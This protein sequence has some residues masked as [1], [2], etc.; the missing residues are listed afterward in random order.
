[1]AREWTENKRL[2]VTGILMGALVLGLGVVLGILVWIWSGVQAESADLGAQR[3]DAENTIKRYEGLNTQVADFKIKNRTDLDKMPDSDDG[4]ALS[5]DITK[6]AQG[7]GV[8]VTGYRPLKPA[9]VKPKQGRNPLQVV[10][11][12]QGSAESIVKLVS[13]LEQKGL[14]YIQVDKITIDGPK[15][16]GCLPDLADKKVEITMTTYYYRSKP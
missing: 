9:G 7:A 15:N 12:G 1:M 4:F 13:S 5:Q 8:V 11:S 2:L 16:G 10:L 14:R 6:L 3:S